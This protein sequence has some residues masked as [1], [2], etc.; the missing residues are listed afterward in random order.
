MADLSHLDMSKAASA[1][2]FTPIPAGDYKAMLVHS[3]VKPTKD[4]TGQRLALRFIIMEGQYQ[5]RLIFEG[6]NIVNKNTTAQGIALRQLQDLKDA[7]G[8][9]NAS[10]SEELHNR[11]LTIK[12]AIKD[13]QNVIKAYKSRSVSNAQQ[14]TNM[15]TEAFSQPA[16][17]TSASP[18]N[19]FAKK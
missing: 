15:M 12:V 7:V 2:S 11:P 8:L 14:Q 19:P 3:E 17:T 13:D 5:N 9:S 1:G 10:Q 6:L 4:G 18:A 16:Q